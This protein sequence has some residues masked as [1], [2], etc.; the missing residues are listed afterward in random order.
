[1][2]KITSE[3]TNIAI[4]GGWNT[5]IF[6]PEWIMANI[7]NSKDVAVGLVLGNFSLP[8]YL[9]FDGLNVNFSA[10]RVVISAEIP[11]DAS[12]I[13]T[14]EVADAIVTKLHHTPLRATGIN[15]RY[16]SDPFEGL[17]HQ[18]FEQPDD[19][20]LADAG[21]IIV[22]KSITRS[23]LLDDLVLN[24]RIEIPQKGNPFIGI[25][26]HKETNTTQAAKEHLANGVVN[27]RD[28][29]KVLL[30]SVYNFDFE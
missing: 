23:T 18:L 10:N 1:M 5:R 25:N 28:R 27:L 22:N 11:D 26:F 14:Q 13:R 17:A 8:F 16:E 9:Q 7:S 30:E 19:S 15:F 29:S 6:T 4:I 21:A 20:A 2:L 3:N 12:L 24:I